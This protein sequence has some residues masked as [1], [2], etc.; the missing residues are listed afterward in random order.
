MEQTERH[1]LARPAAGDDARA[2]HWGLFGDRSVAVVPTCDLPIFTSWQQSVS[3]VVNSWAS[4]AQTYQELERLVEEEMQKVVEREQAIQLILDSMQEGL[5]SCD[6]QGRLTDVRSR[7]IEAWFGAAAD[8]TLVTDY[9]FSADDSARV[10]F[11]MAL[12]QLLEDVL[13]FEV[14]AS[15]LPTVVRLGEQTFRMRVDRVDADGDLAGVVFTLR[16]ATAEIRAEK[17][18]AE[19]RELATVV[20]HAIANMVGFSLFIEEMDAIFDELSQPPERQIVDRLLHTVKGNASLFGFDRFAKLCHD[21]ESEL[22]DG[23]EW[24]GSRADML[25]QTWGDH[26]AQV[27]RI[28]KERER[29]GVRLC[30]DE[31]DAFVESL[32]VR[33]SYDE[34]MASVSGWTRPTVDDMLG[35][36]NERAQRICGCA[37][38][39]VQVEVIGGKTRLPSSG[40]R[41]FMASMVHMVRNAIDHG[42]EAPERRVE[43]GKPPDGAIT[44]R[45]AQTSDTFLLT[46]EDD[47]RG[48]DWS[49][50]AERARRLGLP[51]T[52]DEELVEA[53]FT[54]RL[55]TAASVGL[56][57]GRGVG[58][59]AV[60]RA[61]VALGGSIEI[62]SEPGQG[63]RFAFSLPVFPMTTET[64]RR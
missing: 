5:L 29:E 58:L 38:K 50:V 30:S 43:V 53:L 20:R 13:P 19:A 37:G 33:T 55:S 51:S 18:E 35:N 40:A 2:V 9:L 1:G 32:A 42:I 41:G 27:R 26:S 21:V 59:G 10:Q 52:T 14:C 15:M 16:D 22:A 3:S 36:L 8:G 23:A 25:A 31:Y 45:V 11:H 49:I 47:G 7:A 62:N 54:D 63:T 44:V 6:A 46:F 4:N 17:A 64:T 61:C 56:N 60:R 28:V 57:S 24:S 34:L 12:E 39:R 48:I